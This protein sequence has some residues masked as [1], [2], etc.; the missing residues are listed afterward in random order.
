MHR[1]ILLSWK[2]ILT[3]LTIQPLQGKRS[4]EGIIFFFF[5]F[6]N[7]FWWEKLFIYF[8]IPIT[9]IHTFIHT[10][11]EIRRSLCPHINIHTI[12]IYTRYFW[13][14]FSCNMLIQ[15]M[16]NKINQEENLSVT[17]VT[18]ELSYCTCCIERCI[19]V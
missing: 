12:F 3:Q 4:T 9:F 2:W 16:R 15:I 5:F 19:P 10:F 6:F 8:W 18:N 1:L 11:I 17:F 7:C 13:H 14:Y